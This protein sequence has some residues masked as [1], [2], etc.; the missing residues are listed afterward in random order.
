[1]EVELSYTI[2]TTEGDESFNAKFDDNNAALE[3]F[4]S[5]CDRLRGEGYN[6]TEQNAHKLPL[7]IDGT[8]FFIKPGEPLAIVQA[9]TDYEVLP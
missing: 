2:A 3:Y 1:M 9:T 6:C 5:E 8:A 4:F 7:I